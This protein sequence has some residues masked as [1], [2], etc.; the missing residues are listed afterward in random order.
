[1]NAKTRWHKHPA[2]EE[3]LA[4]GRKHGR[5]DADE[6]QAVIEAHDVDLDALDELF[7][8]LHDQD[9]RIVDAVDADEQ[10]QPD[11]TET[12]DLADW[13][14]SKTADPIADSVRYYLQQM[15]KVPLLRPQEEKRL[16]TEINEQRCRMAEALLLHPYSR[17][18]LSG[19]LKSLREGEE[20]PHA[21]MTVKEAQR[22]TIMQ[23]INRLSRSLERWGQARGL[24][25][26]PK[27]LRKWIAQFDELPWVED[28]FLLLAEHVLKLEAA[29]RR[30]SRA[31]LPADPDLDN[32][33]RFLAM[34]ELVATAFAQRQRAREA[35][36]NANLRLV[37][38]IAKRYLNRGL[39]MLDLI[40][41]GNIGLMRAVEKFDVSRGF[42][43][44]TYATWWIRQAM[45]RALA[46]Q[47]RTIRV[48]VHMVD[49]LN[50]VRTTGRKL[51]RKWGRDPSVA[52]LAQ[53]LE[54]PGERLE[55]LLRMAKDPVSLDAPLGEDQSALGDLLEDVDARDPMEVTA[56]KD[57][58]AR[59]DHL[60]DHLDAREGAILR[61][62]FG[63]GYDRTYTLE[64][65]G[66][67]F[68]ITRERVRQIEI[69]ALRKLRSPLSHEGLNQLLED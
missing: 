68:A 40:Q 26:A 2:G 29:Y 58:R 33:D 7:G 56:D 27:K 11:A 67:S 9:I 32:V 15:G 52:E 12:P 48:P 17:Q 8:W 51:R 39:T 53:A 41:E 54:L 25:P 50:K 38:N 24:S 6:I 14:A 31:A 13:L 1:M 3:L 61:L 37:V 66:R 49:V 21:W 42:K 4:L 20:Q 35:M 44:S 64:E 18:R 63:I 5:L 46:D 45:I 36:V 62:R 30:D 65:V 55:G 19:L 16:A 23:T 34:C 47:S 28:P 57:F 43:F 59:I 69:K 60:L 10:T 22:K